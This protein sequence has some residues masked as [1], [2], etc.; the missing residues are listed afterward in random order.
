[1]HS[2]QQADALW[3]AN[4]EELMRMLI[5]CLAALSMI[6]GSAGVVVPVAAANGYV[7][8]L[9]E[10]PSNIDVDINTEGGDWWANPLWIGIG[11]VAL[12][13]LIAVVAM[14]SRGGGTTIIKE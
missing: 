5:A 9:Q 8:A 12:I 13:L 1:L 3:Q 11:I 14:A 10:I 2:S 7:V 6:A 4:R